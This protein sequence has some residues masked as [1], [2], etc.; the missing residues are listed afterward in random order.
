M[1]LFAHKA[2]NIYNLGLYQKKFANPNCREKLEL[3]AN[4]GRDGRAPRER[5]EEVGDG[6]CVPGQGRVPWQGRGGEAALRSGQRAALSL[7][8][9]SRRKLQVQSGV[10]DTKEHLWYQT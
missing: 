10:T 2:E 7:K 3:N 1:C 9:L 8:S 6:F 4:V 5:A